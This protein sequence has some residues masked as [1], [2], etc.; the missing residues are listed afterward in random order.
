[1]IKVDSEREFKLVRNASSV[2][3]KINL[4]DIGFDQVS[5]SNIYI[6]QSDVYKLLN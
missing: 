4:K 6:Y 3:K 1:M 5:D 2:I